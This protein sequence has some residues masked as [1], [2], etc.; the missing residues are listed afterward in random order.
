M[1]K[2]YV[3]DVAQESKRKCTFQQ[4]FLLRKT[5]LETRPFRFTE[6]VPFRAFSMYSSGKGTT[7]S[8]V[9]FRFAFCIIK[10]DY[11]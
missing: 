5:H 9:G 4:E 11:P 3:R 1:F 8:S 6:Q 2:F 7:H 10:C